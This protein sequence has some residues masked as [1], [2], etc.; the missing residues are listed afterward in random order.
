MH[1]EYPRDLQVVTPVGVVVCAVTDGNHIYVQSEEGQ[2]LV[3]SGKPL[4]ASVHLMR[5]NGKW[6]HTNENGH[7]TL[8]CRKWECL[9]T[10]KDEA[11]ATQKGKVLEAIVPAVTDW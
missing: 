8:Y 7:T 9:Y 10:N 5:R 4:R 11:T 2:P 6:E 1:I 3:V